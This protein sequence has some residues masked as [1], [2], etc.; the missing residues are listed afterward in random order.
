MH[1]TNNFFKTG[2]QC[3]GQQRHLG[4]YSLHELDIKPNKLDHRNKKT[5]S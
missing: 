4:W 3:K 2:L 1:V 5:L